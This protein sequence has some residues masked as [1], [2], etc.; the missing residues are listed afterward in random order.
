MSNNSYIVV[1]KRE[2]EHPQATDDHLESC[3]QKVEQSGGSIKH[4]Y[5]SR[6][7]RGFAGTFSDDLKAEFEKSDAVK[8]VA[9]HL[10]D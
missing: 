1:F 8:Y 3:A 7:M 5:N 10:T 6:S 4:R 9:T 2:D